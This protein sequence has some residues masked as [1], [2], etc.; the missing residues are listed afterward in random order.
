VAAQPLNDTGII[1]LTVYHEDRAQAD[2][3]MRAVISTMLAK[4][5]EY[6]GAGDQVGI[7]TIDQPVTSNAP[8]KPNIF[9][10]LLAGLVM[11]IIFSFVYVY[12]YPEEK[13]NIDKI[14]HKPL[15]Q[16]SPNLINKI[17]HEE[18]VI[19]N[20]PVKPMPVN[21]NFNN[22]LPDQAVKEAPIVHDNQVDDLDIIKSGD[23]LNI[24]R[25]SNLDN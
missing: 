16:P 6:H 3:I 17:N 11:G 2:Q 13:Y 5:Q 4:H 22:Y 12:L 7:R 1:N 14:F 25:Q 10:N 8:V 24:F 23:M 15:A 21:T 18:K 19:S 20:E 9:L